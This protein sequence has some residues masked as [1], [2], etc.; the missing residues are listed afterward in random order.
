MVGRAQA[1]VVYR[2]EE[3]D[4]MEEDGVNGQFAPKGQTKY[5]IWKWKGGV[6]CHHRWYRVIYVRKRG[7]GGR[8]LPRSTGPDMENDKK[9]SL[10]QARAQGIPEEVLNPSGWPDAATR[11]ID[12]PT[13]G[14]LN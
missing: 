10:P 7:E 12:T 8:F 2:K 3:I 14:K 5:S 6:Y 11:P 9:V 4:R 1:N 13:R